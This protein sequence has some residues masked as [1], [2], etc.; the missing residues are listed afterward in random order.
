[1]DDR[2]QTNLQLLNQLRG[3]GYPDDDVTRIKKAYDFVSWYFAGWFRASGKPFV[4]HLVGTAGI[5]AAIRART[6]VVA[7]GLSH[8]VYA[9]GELPAGSPG[10]ARPAR[11]EVRRALGVEAEDLVARYEALEW[12]ARTLP[13][14]RDR[15][16]GL[17]LADR[18]VVLIRLA[19]E[20]DDHLDL[21]VLYCA[22][23]EE[24]RQ[25][26]GSG[27]RLAVEIARDLA[28]PQLAAT[29]DR[30]FEATLS[31]QLPCALRT[32]HSASFSMLA[33]LGSSR[34]AARL[35]RIVGGVKRR[36]AAWLR[37]LE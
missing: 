34:R 17:P 21:G 14:L 25:E 35:R 3:A 23:A 12:N 11:E 4:A 22:N 13:S 31:A 28:F 8:S 10:A 33:T 15:L 1:M 36:A 7:A 26:I 20:L 29:L 16:P 9:L 37:N 30:A 18:E 6:P 19:N 24:R 27:L 5:L 32:D 2:P